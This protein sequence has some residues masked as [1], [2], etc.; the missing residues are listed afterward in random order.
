MAF[1]CGH[2]YYQQSMVSTPVSSITSLDARQ[3]EDLNRIT[4]LNVLSLLGQTLH[5]INR[6]N[7]ERALLYFL[8]ALVAFKSTKVSFA[9]QGVL[10]FDRMVGGLTGVR[11]LKALFEG[12]NR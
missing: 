2:R 9:L 10:T 8:T 3:F 4:K 5:E 7:E 6:G 12:Q 11:P 1:A